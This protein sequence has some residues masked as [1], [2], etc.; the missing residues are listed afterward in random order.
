MKCVM[1]NLHIAFRFAIAYMKTD[2]CAVRYE[3]ILG[4]INTFLFIIL[5]IDSSTSISQT[6]CANRL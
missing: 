4:Q 5:F 3:L 2:Q 6:L 1:S